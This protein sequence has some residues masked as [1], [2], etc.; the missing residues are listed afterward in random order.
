MK[1]VETHDPLLLNEIAKRV[2]QIKGVDYT[3]EEFILYIVDGYADHTTKVFIAQDENDKYKMKGFV[4]ASI[5]KPMKDKEI[6][7]D[8]SWIDSKQNGL[9]K[10]LMKRVEDWA[11]EL[12]IKLITAYITKGLR[13]F[14]K[15]YGFKK[16]CILISKEVHYGKSI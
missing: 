9:G 8:L 16:K 2:K 7:V 12:K 5:V 15:R 6:F 11:R 10:D 13:A 4:V 3:P 1:I 14:K